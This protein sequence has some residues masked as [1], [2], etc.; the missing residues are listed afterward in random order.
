MGTPQQPTSGERV[1]KPCVDPD[2]CTGCGTCECTCPAVFQLGDDE[3][4]HVIDENPPESEWDAVRDAADGC[5][6]EAISIEE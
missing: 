2:L 5:P 4:S 1:F 3:L 6:S